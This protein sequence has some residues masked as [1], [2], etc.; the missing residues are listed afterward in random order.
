MNDTSASVQKQLFSLRDEAYKAFQ[1]KLIP[2]VDPET[3]IG[4]R[5]PT[6]RRFARAFAKTEEVSFFMENLPHEY[7]EENNL[8]AFLIESIENF[9]KTAEALDRFL[10][11][12]DNWATC[13]SMNPKIFVQNKEK[14]LSVI[15]K[16]L[17]SE[18]TYAVRFALVMLMKHYLDESFSTMIVEKA[19]SVSSDFYYIAMAQ[20]W[21]FAEALVKHYDQTLPFLQER[22]LSPWVH[23]KTISKACDSFRIPSEKKEFL[24]TLRLKKDE[25]TAIYD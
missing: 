17:I 4:I 2:T 19:A 24:R 21:F 11:Y 9:E 3:V 12:V 10:P 18:H 6:L 14:L 16:W 5:T 22:R 8:H 13:D 1:A 25:E 7:Y 23:N 20:A 15:E